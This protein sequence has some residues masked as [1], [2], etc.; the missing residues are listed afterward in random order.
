M[1]DHGSAI[2]ET[3]S[4]SN[5]SGSV[6]KST[7]HFR[8]SA[9]RWTK[10]NMFGPQMMT[11]IIR[12][13][14]KRTEEEISEIPFT[15]LHLGDAMQLSCKSEFNRFRDAINKTGVPWAMAPGNHDGFY[16]GITYPDRGR[17]M[18]KE[19]KKNIS[20]LLDNYYTGWGGVCTPAREDEKNCEGEQGCDRGGVDKVLPPMGKSKWVPSAEPNIVRREL[21]LE[22]AILP[23]YKVIENLIK[24]N[25]LVPNLEN[26]EGC[27]TILIND[28]ATPIKR[29]QFCTYAKDKP[30]ASYILQELVFD[31]ASSGSTVAVFMIDTGVMKT[32][33]HQVIWGG[34]SRKGRLGS[35]QMKK[36][37]KWISD[38][39]ADIK[40]V[41]GHQPFKKIERK[42]RGLLK[43]LFKKEKVSLYLSAH[44]HD[45]YDKIHSLGKNDIT[46]EEVFF[47]EHNISSLIDTP[48]EYGVLKI[49]GAEQGLKSTSLERRIVTYDQAAN[50][51][52]PKGI[53]R[54]HRTVSIEFIDDCKDRKLKMSDEENLVP[55]GEIATNFKVKKKKFGVGLW[56]EFNSALAKKN[57][58]LDELEVYEGLIRT[59]PVLPNK[60][61]SV[62]F[63]SYYA[64]ENCDEVSEVKSNARNT[65]TSCLT[66]LDDKT[67]LN[68][69]ASARKTL[70]KNPETIHKD[71]DYPLIRVSRLLSALAIYEEHRSNALDQNDYNRLKGC[72]AISPW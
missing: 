8:G 48:L 35:L 64:D 56:K 39:D 38:S 20:N 10:L 53:K 21:E 23:K 44:T 46:N 72:I 4:A 24:E 69:I 3:S 58:F 45:G 34:P 61:T 37:E 62:Y 18:S 70:N 16:S 63:R 71:G 28:T 47:T 19:H 33:P 9:R 57:A 17:V 43:I 65:E 36:L 29:V 11:E 60:V 7:G 52:L 40:I 50:P 55:L 31:G 49:N 26:F 27:D 25:H 22:K 12:A 6:S 1:E 2:K 51:I 59:H 32:R 66:I 42:E 14:V 41:A 5:R 15:I 13:E 54:R 30:W 67:A 68:F